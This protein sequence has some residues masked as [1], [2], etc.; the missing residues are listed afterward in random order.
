MEGLM[1]SLDFITSHDNYLD[2]LYEALM[3]LNTLCKKNHEAKVTLIEKQGFDPKLV[4]QLATSFDGNIKMREVFL[5][6]S[7]DLILMNQI[8]G[9]FTDTHLNDMCFKVSE[10]KLAEDF[11]IALVKNLKDRNHE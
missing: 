6:L 8:Y 7:V 11:G 10:L 3:L 9:S 4:T 5:H 1:F 2:Y